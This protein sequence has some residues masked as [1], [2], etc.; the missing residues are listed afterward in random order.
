M[1]RINITVDKTDKTSIV[2]LTAAGRVDDVILALKT[3]EQMTKKLGT[4]DNTLKT[5]I[6]LDLAPQL[7]LNGGGLDS[8]I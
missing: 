4:E 2:N 1:T 7:D 8:K 3:V 6:S 5:F